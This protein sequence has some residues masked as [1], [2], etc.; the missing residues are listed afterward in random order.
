MP[1]EALRETWQAKVLTATRADPIGMVAIS[2]LA[3][4]YDD[5]MHPLLCALYPGFSGLKP[6]GLCSAGKIAK[7][8]SV[9]ADLVARNGTRLLGCKIFNDEIHLR[10]CFR[11]LADNLKLADAERIELFEA[12]RKWVVCDYRLD[13]RMDPRDPDAK[14][15]AVN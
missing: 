2:V 7:N 3:H 14:R 11:R 13:P 6:P 15:Y 5:A 10:D 4:N 8:G 9:I 12:V 1:A